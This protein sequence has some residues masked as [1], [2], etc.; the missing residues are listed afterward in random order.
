MLS[1]HEP[2][3]QREHQLQL[4]GFETDLLAKLVDTR[5]QNTTSES[6]NLFLAGGIG[7]G[8]WALGGF[9]MLYTY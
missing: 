2:A 6:A 1:P 5:Y 3:L 4:I 9:T 8:I 7:D